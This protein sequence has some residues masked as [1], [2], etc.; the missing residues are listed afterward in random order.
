MFSMKPTLKKWVLM[1]F[2]MLLAII[3][4]LYY[5]FGYVPI[6]GNV[7]A[8]NKLSEYVGYSVSSDFSFPYG[9]GYSVVFR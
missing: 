7:I 1:L 2:I 4:G 5:L 6:V 9:D 3:G 8:N